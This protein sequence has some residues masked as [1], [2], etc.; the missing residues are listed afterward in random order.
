MAYY[1]NVGP[2]SG[3]LLSRAGYFAIA[4]LHARQAY[5]PIGTA[6]TDGPDEDGL[7]LWRL[8]INEAEVPGLWIVLDREFR[9]AG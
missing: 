9:P 8:T 4:V 7:A 6:L 5:A 2:P 1:T 3:P